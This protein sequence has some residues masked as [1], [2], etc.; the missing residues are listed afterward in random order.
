LTE[1]LRKAYGRFLHDPII[2]VD[3]KE[4][5]KP[6]FIADGEFGRPGKYELRGE[7]TVAEAVAIA[8]GFTDKAKHSDVLLFRRVTG[9]W[10]QAERMD[11]KQMLATGDLGEDIHI[12]PGDF[13]YVP[14]SK[15][16]KV[17][18]FIPNMGMGLTI[19]YR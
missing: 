3:L 18:Q 17:R 16:G 4:F 8:G 11:V 1:L 15:L 5:E 13:L 6:Y 7:T 2:N 10:E 12:R 14:K 19:P 9:G